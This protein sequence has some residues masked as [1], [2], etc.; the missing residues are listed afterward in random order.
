MKIN[1]ENTTFHGI[2]LKSEEHLD[3]IKSKTLVE[4]TI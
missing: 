1:K 2:S 3:Q 4:I